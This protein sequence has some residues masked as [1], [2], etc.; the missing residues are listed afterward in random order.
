MIRSVTIQPQFVSEQPV[1]E[2]NH[3]LETRS[4]REIGLKKSDTC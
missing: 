2:T 4:T 1:S 3:K